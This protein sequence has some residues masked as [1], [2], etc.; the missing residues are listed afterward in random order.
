MASLFRSDNQDDQLERQF[1]HQQHQTNLNALE[2]EDSKYDKEHIEV[3]TSNDLDAHTNRLLRNLVEK[4]FVLSNLKDAEVNEIKWLAR[5]MARKVKRMHPP[6]ESVVTGEYRK[7][8][9]DDPRDALKPLT[10]NQENLI[11]QGMMDFF[12][13]L[14][15]SRDGWQQDE[16][17][18]QLR[19]SRTENDPD[20]DTSG[21]FF[22]L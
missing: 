9:L 4:D 8:L 1:A 3:L 14:A 11:D 5:S 13:R 15:R 17:G 18:K 6:Q 2:P 10:P 21:G 12:S 20:D 22:S 16:M 19:V 7:F